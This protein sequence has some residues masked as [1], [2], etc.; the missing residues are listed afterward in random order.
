ME[1]LLLSRRGSSLQNVPGGMGRNEEKWL[2][3]HRLEK[4]FK[5]SFIT[6]SFL[7]IRIDNVSSEK[8][9]IIVKLIYSQIE[10]LG[11]KSCY[12]LCH[13]LGGVLAY[14]KVAIYG[15]L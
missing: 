2:L 7:Y 13:D 12:L 9:L 10:A 8:I 5:V 3:I 6:V 15:I 11:Y 1:F 14:G 4:I